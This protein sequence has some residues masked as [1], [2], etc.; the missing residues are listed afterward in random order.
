LHSFYANQLARVG[1]FLF[2]VVFLSGAG[3][4]SAVK[5]LRLRLYSGPGLNT[6]ER[7]V[8][9]GLAAALG[10]A[11][12]CLPYGLWVEPAWLEVTHEEVSTPKLLPGEHLRIALIS[13]LHVAG[14][15]RAL[16]QAVSAI[17]AAH[18]DLVVFTGDALNAQDGLPVFRDALSQ[19]RA[20][21]GRF[22]VR[23]NHD[24]WYWKSTD[25]FGGGVAQELTGAPVLLRGSRVALCGAPFGA[26]ERVAACLAHAPASALRVV[27]YHTPDFVE[28]AAASHAD[29]YLAGHTHGGQVRL[30]GYGA[31]ITMSKFDKKYE[32]GRYDV[33]GG[34]LY[35]TLLY[36]NRGIG[37]E[38]WLPRFRFLCRPEVTV[39][40]VIG[41]EKN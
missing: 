25:L 36:V 13:D 27:A 26:T 12:P 8:L 24:V 3:L 11:L 4:Y 16:A 31:V 5:L 9:K 22:A 37:E 14:K 40:D 32:A 17:N 29:I 1:I 15:S 38:R 2:L 28:D 33:A 21:E 39:I 6:R 30:P 20:K 7:R 35:R 10:L 18:P 34:D 23:G 19:M 41:E